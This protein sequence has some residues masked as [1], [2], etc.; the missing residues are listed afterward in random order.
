MNPYIELVPLKICN[1]QG[2][3]PSYAALRALDYA[4]EENIDIINMSLG[5]RANPNG[6]SICEGIAAYTQAGGIVVTAA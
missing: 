6:H 4:R 3:C 5:G 1:A 2:F